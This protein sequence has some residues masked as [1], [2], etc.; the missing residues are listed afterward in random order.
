[1]NISEEIWKKSGARDNF[2]QACMQDFNAPSQFPPPYE[3]VNPFL[4]ALIHLKTACFKEKTEN[5]IIIMNEMMKRPPI[6]DFQTAMGDGINP[7][8]SSAEQGLLARVILS[9]DGRLKSLNYELSINIK[10]WIKIYEYLR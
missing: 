3:R 6:W 8:P 1:M 7:R 2:E 10:Q 5:I 9:A 4:L